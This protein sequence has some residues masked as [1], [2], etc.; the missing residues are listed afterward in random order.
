MVIKTEG[1]RFFME[2]AENL[3][4]EAVEPNTEH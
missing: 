3:P 2:N 4:V 1:F